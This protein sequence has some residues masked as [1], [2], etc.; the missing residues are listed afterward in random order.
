MIRSFLIV[1]RDCI[2]KYVTWQASA[3]CN[4]NVNSYHMTFT[5]FN[6]KK[7]E[8]VVMEKVST[9]PTEEVHALILEKG[10]I[11]QELEALKG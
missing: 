5:C 2:D 3:N 9:K 8:M 7:E 1:C 10:N 6:C 4:V 11:E